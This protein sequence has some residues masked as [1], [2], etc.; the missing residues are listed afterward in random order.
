MSWGSAKVG[1][2]DRLGME[3]LGEV[4]ERQRERGGPA[5]TGGGLF[6]PVVC[7]GVGLPQDAK[8]RLP[9]DDTRS[10]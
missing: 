9:A 10:V 7:G 8:M 6:W 3:G 1:L 4:R 2:L 5:E